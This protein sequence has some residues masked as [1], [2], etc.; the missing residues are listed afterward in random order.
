MDSPMTGRATKN[1]T[2]RGLH[3]SKAEKTVSLA[4]QGGGAHGAFTWGVLD[5]LLEDGRLAIEAISGAS[6]G[7]M[8]AVV[9]A[10]GF[11]EGGMEGARRQLRQFWEQ[12]A[13]DNRFNPDQTGVMRHVFGFWPGMQMF[14]QAAESFGYTVADVVSRISSPYDLN[15]LDYNPLRDALEDLIDFDKVKAC[16]C[17]KLFISATNVW[18]GKGR[19]FERHELSA[20][21]I[22]ASA[23]LP[24][25][26][27]AVEI[28]GVPYWDGG[29]MGNPVLYPLFYGI[30]TDDILLVQ[31]NP[32]ERRDTPKTA[33]EIQ[34][35]M[36]EITFNGGL[37]RELRAVEFVTRLI[38]QDKIS[39]AE[40]KNVLMHRIDGRGTLDDYPASSRLNSSSAFFE[41]LFTK[42]RDA[43][44]GWLKKHYDSIGIEATL[45]VKKAYS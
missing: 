2:L 36:T 21:H 45:D 7:A 42:G 26:F 25:L 1:H 28:E 22:M 4:L 30:A 5:A 17:V 31:I 16:D 12:V 8:N 32:V 29:Y 6:A 9:M 43:A 23:C 27:K 35:R 10:E 13:S 40:Y 33:R 11:I 14:H 3:G 24:T 15:P 19:V 20:D 39:S 37:L 18:T 44:Q 41:E 38:A 34:D